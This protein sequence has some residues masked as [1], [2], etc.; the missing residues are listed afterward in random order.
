MDKV[1]PLGYRTEWA[2]GAARNICQSAEYFM[3]KKLCEIGPLVFS[4]RLLV[5]REFLVFLEGDWMRELS[6]IDN[7]M[8]EIQ[9]MR[10]DITRYI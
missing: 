9:D 7:V 2:R 8:R 10:H 1:T 5:V 4:P 6:W 3:Q